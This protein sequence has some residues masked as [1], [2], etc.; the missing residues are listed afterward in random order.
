MLNRLKTSFIYI[1]I[2]GIYLFLSSL[3]GKY[4]LNIPDEDFVD[5]I[6]ISALLLAIII[7]VGAM[8]IEFVYWVV[9]GKSFF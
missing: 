1:L 2:I 9:T 4:I 3:A 6:L 8:A 7:I 5:Q